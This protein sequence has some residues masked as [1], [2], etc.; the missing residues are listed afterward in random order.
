MIV[1]LSGSTMAVMRRDKPATATRRR[2]AGALLGGLALAGLL[3]APLPAA[4]EEAPEDPLAQ[5]EEGMRQILTALQLLLATIPQY[6]MPEVLENGDIII[7]R[8]QPETPADPDDAN[9]DGVEET[10][11]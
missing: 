6:A 7:R 1:P 5:A 9:D 8:V 10:A 3:W 2:P 4:A 11:I